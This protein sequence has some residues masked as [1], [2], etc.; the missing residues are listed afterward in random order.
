MIRRY[1]SRDNPE[2]LRMRRALWP[3]IAR[4]PNREKQDTERWLARHDATVF[5]FDREDHD[6]LGGF[7]EAGERAFA[8][9]CDTQ[10]VGY[11]EGWFVDADLRGQGIG[12]TLMTAAEQWAKARGYRELASDAQ[13]EA[14]QSQ[15]AHVQLGFTEVERAVRY[16]KLL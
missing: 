4:D 12:R 6:R 5:V 16:K 8:D 15:A 10:P 1:N 2:W 9:G 11:I 14:A 3:D 7:L 13:L